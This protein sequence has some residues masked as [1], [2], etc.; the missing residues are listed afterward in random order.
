MKRRAIA[1]LLVT[2]IILALTFTLAVGDI[3]L[4]PEKAGSL[5]PMAQATETQLTKKP[6]D[7][8]NFRA[9]IMNTGTK[10]T[11]YIIRVKYAEHG[12][13]QWETAA[14][15]DTS[16]EPGAYKHM[17]LGALELTEEMAGKH[18]DALFQLMDAE[19]GTLLDEAVLEKA[20][21][22]EEPITA[23]S[24]IDRWVY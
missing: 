13:G 1:P 2:L 18:Y 5:I 9:K 10:A 8:V 20:W 12:T 16:L 19:T 24:I 4:R 23:G 15:E 3:I 14:L 17:E 6:G 7:T 11:G 21:Y 22:V